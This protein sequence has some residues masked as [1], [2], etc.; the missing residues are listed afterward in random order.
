MGRPQ[1]EALAA[2]NQ[3]IVDLFINHGKRVKD[4]LVQFGVTER[5]VYKI[6]NAAGVSS[7]DR[8]VRPATS[9]YVSRRPI[10][11]RHAQVGFDISTARNRLGIHSVTE[12]GKR[13]LITG[14]RMKDIE[15]GIH[16]WT[17]TEIERVCAV[18]AQKP[19][20][21]VRL[22]DNFRPTT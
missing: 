15:D 5:Q 21:L 13:C 19:E 6:L 18:I 3:T 14:S 22:R 12:M 20:E 9:H 2:R 7:K 1:D 8:T 4:L 10:S 11:R 17:W 16:D